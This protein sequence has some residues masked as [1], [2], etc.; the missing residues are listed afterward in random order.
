MFIS[1]LIKE[2]RT[3]HMIT[4]DYLIYIENS[5]STFYISEVVNCSYEHKLKTLIKK[6]K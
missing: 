6:Y 2:S 4:V 1:R 3:I 5:N